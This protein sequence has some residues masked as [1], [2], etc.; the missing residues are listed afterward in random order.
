MSLYYFA[1]GANMDAND[2]SHRCDMNRRNTV[3]F[4][5]S[6]PA[7]LKG[8]SLATNVF[9]PRRESGIFNVVPDREGIVQGVLHKLRPGDIVTAR[10]LGE[11]KPNTF[12]VRTLTVTNRHGEELPAAV[13]VAP[14]RG[15]SVYRP[16]ASYLALVVEAARRHKLP[17][18]WIDFLKNFPT[19]PEGTS[20]RV[21]SQKPRQK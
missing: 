2:L 17:S 11:G 13:L 8:Y 19:V 12:R 5:S 10:D 20:E 7:S 16:V 18:A 6:A 3:H 4:L 1:Y 15:K 21:S 9:C 14:I